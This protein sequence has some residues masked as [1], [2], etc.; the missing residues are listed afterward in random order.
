MLGLGQTADSPCPARHG[1]LEAERKGVG[2]KQEQ[3]VQGGVSS[4]RH[5]RV[6]GD[7]VLLGEAM[8][9]GKRVPWRK[10]EGK[11][12]E[13]GVQGASHLDVISV[14]AGIQYHWGCDVLREVGSVGDRVGTFMALCFPKAVYSL[15]QVFLG[16]A[17]LH[18]RQVRLCFSCGRASL[19]GVCL[20]L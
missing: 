11:K 7:P 18:T 8:C 14:K 10:G 6:G 12:Q 13:Q 9:F 3:G 17:A 4:R 2:K 1:T 16:V 19:T 20:P 15:A 5:P